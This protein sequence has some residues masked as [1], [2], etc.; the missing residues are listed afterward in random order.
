VNLEVAGLEEGEVSCQVINNTLI[1]RGAR[2][3]RRVSEDAKYHLSERVYGAFERMF[4][5]PSDVQAEKLRTN[6]A[7]GILEI[8]IPKTEAAGRTEENRQEVARGKAVQGHEEKIGGKKG[9]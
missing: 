6:L 3:F 2:R 7:N 5:L 8:A 9:Q 1:V 4:P